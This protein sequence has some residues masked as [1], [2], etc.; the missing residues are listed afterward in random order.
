[1]MGSFLADCDT[2]SI[3]CVFKDNFTWWL[4]SCN[5]DQ[6]MHVSYNHRF[7]YSLCSWISKELGPCWAATKGSPQP[8]WQDPV[9]AIAHQQHQEDDDLQ[10]HEEHTN[11]PVG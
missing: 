9:K 3:A 5:T 10:Q 11:S 2:G 7:L 6:V 1:M 4:S 8:G